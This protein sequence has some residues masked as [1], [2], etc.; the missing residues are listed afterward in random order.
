MH[1]DIYLPKSLVHTAMRTSSSEQGLQAT[2]IENMTKNNNNT[3][4]KSY[5][6]KDKHFSLVCVFLSNLVSH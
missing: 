3:L 2:E 6:R 4:I 5:Y 1:V